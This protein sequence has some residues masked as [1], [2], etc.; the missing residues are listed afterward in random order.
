MAYI[1]TT[2]GTN[3]KNFLESAVGLVTKDYMI[4]Q[5]GGMMNEANDKQREVIRR[6]MRELEDM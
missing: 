4:E 2:T 3:S 5:L 1:T 6:A